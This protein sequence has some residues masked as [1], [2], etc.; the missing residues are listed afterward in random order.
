M[1]LSNNVLGFL[2]I[3]F[4]YN[5]VIFKQS[6]GARNRVGIGLLYRPAKLHRLA[7]LITW[8]RFLGSLKFK[9]LGSADNRSTAKMLSM[10]ELNKVTRVKSRRC[11]KK[12]LRKRGSYNVELPL[13]LRTYSPAT[14]TSTA[15]PFEILTDDL[16]LG[17]L[18]SSFFMVAN[19]SQSV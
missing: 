14:K 1:F 8:N 10:N 9:N 3:L 12:Q 17:L 15:G 16:S 7:E 13:A 11:K 19:P 6:M 4:A 18:L 5:A 2:T